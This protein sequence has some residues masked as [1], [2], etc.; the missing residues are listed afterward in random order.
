MAQSTTPMEDLTEAFKPTTLEIHNDSHLHSHHKAMQGV[1]S[2]EACI[3]CHFIVIVAITSEKFKEARMQ[4]ARHRMVY[5]L[6]KDELAQEGGIHA[7]QLKTRTPE[8]E[9]RQKQKEQA[10]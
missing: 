9:E 2:K 1:T 6:L 8:E 7:L 3:P 10:E 4:P 5:A